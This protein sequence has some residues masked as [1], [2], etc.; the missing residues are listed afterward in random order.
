MFQCPWF[1]SGMGFWGLLVDWPSLYWDVLVWKKST[2]SVQPFCH[3]R[4]RVTILPALQLP[5]KDSVSCQCLSFV[6]L[7][8]EAA[9]QS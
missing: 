9:E 5:G 2:A 1:N 6:V 3:P 8:T 4:L 7:T